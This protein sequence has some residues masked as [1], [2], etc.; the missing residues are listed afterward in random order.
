MTRKIEPAIVS[1]SNENAKELRPKIYTTFDSSSIINIPAL[2]FKIKHDSL[3]ISVKKTN[4]VQ[5]N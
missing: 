3:R 1:T 5:I 2:R 4:R